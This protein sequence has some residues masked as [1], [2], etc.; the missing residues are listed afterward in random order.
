MLT[1]KNLIKKS[2]WAVSYRQIW[3]SGFN[4][5]YKLLGCKFLFE[6]IWRIN[7]MASSLLNEENLGTHYH[8][9]N[10]AKER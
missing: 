3:I 1:F 5:V 10:P 9:D 6:L 2:L 4:S 7:I 8:A